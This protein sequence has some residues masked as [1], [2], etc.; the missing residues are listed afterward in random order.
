MCATGVQLSVPGA[1]DFPKQHALSQ[2]VH[3]EVIVFPSGERRAP[4]GRQACSLLRQS[5]FGRE[6]CPATQ[7]IPCCFRENQVAVS[8]KDVF[9]HLWPLVLEGQFLYYFRIISEPSRS[10]RR[11]WRIPSTWIFGHTCLR[12]LE[13]RSST[14]YL[15]SWYIA[16]AAVTQDTISATQR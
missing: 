1:G 2:A 8:P 3:V 9:V 11:L 7:T 15:L 5:C 14:P 4:V 6:Q 16:V 13:N 12:Q 10:L